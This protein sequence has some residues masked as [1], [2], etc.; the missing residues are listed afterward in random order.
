MSPF[1]RSGAE[2]QTRGDVSARER[3]YHAGSSGLLLNRRASAVIS[4][5]LAPLGM[6]STRQRESFVVAV[7]P[8]WDLGAFG[9]CVY[10]CLI[11]CEVAWR[12]IDAHHGR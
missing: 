5:F 12:C 2:I 4:F 9:T 1:H 6:P 10:R 11:D 7:R 8:G 3:E